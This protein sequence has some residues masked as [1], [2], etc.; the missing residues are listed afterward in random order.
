MLDRHKDFIF[1]ME[2]INIKIKSFKLFLLKNKVTT[3]ITEIYECMFH[4]CQYI[5]IPYI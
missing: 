4:L 3:R 2:T 1:L 5:V